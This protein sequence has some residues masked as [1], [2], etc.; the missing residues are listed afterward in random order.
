M[1]LNVFNCSKQIQA[2]RTDESVDVGST[3]GGYY[4]GW[5]KTGEFLHYTVNVLSDGKIQAVF[6]YI[7]LLYSLFG[8]PP[9]NLLMVDL[10]RWARLY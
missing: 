10:R 5:M 1:T 4:V 6:C 7:L 9:D 2:F 3:R 8:V